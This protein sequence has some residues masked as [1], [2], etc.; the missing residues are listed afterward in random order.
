MAEGGRRMAVSRISHVGIAV[1]SLDEAV[2]LYEKI[3]GIEASGVE[4]VEDQ[5][6][7]VA[8]FQVGESRIELLEPIDGG[9]PIGAFLEK[10]GQGIHHIAFEVEGLEGELARLKEEGVRLIDEKPRRGAGGASIAFVHPKSVCGVL[11]ELCEHGHGED[12]GE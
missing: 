3:L 2:P 1:K 6:V 9:G 5:G 11:T 12:G 4:V 8:F 10:R 7:R